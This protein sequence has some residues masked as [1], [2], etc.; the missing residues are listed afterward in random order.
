MMVLLVARLVFPPFL[1]LLL[2]VNV[3]QNSSSFSCLGW[4]GFSLSLGGKLVKGSAYNCDTIAICPAFATNQGTRCQA[5]ISN[6]YHLFKKAD[7]SVQAIT[8]NV[9]EQITD[10]PHARL[11]HP[12]FLSF[13]VIITIL[14][15]HLHWAFVDFFHIV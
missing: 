10:L 14:I 5:V 13:F 1:F 7:L 6:I 3:L 15:T 9:V 12:N 11:N 8:L 2:P 4:S